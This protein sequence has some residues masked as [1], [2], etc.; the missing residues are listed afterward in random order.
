LFI[1]DHVLLS[2]QELPGDVFDPVRKRTRTGA[3]MRHRGPDYLAY[4]LIDVVIDGY[5]PVLNPLG[6]RLE[7]LE[8]EITLR[9]RQDQIPSVMALRH[10]LQALRR[11]IVPMRDLVWQMLREESPF[12]AEGTLTHLRD[13]YDHA[14]Q[15]VDVVD[16]FVDHTSQLIALHGSMMSNRMNEIMKVLTI[17]STIFIPLGFLAGVYGMNFAWIPELGFRYG[18]FI[19]LGVMVTVAGLLLL[20]FRRRGWLGRG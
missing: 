5:F 12:L 15:I 14:A 13:C 6:N 7:V 20:Y 3:R 1:G 16:G 19:L 9:T 11:D 18:Y 4:A 10:E 8:E 2:I 17:M